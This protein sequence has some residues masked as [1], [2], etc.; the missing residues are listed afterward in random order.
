MVKRLFITDFDGT[1]LRDDKQ[2]STKDIE[3]LRKMQN[4]DVICTIATGRSLYS[5]NK[6]ADQIKINSKIEILPIDYIIF[7][8]G[9][10]VMR[11]ADS[12]I[13]YSETLEQA[14]V[15]KIVSYFEMK[16]FDYMVHGG[17]RETH[18]FG[19]K[20]NSVCN[21]DFEARINLYQD[22][23]TPL[24]SNFTEFNDSTEVIAIIPR[25]IEASFLDEI[26]SDL[27]GYS[28][29]HA[30]SPLDHQSAWIEVFNKDV[31]KSRTADWL[32]RHLNI[33][34]ENII[35]VGND[36]ND[37]DLLAWTARGFI[38]ENAPIKLKKRFE[39]VLSNNESGVSHA[40]KV[41]GFLS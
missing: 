27:P 23:A 32:S 38:V 6:A 10:G 12:K 1:L 21:P 31:S 39:I 15:K 4:N 17:I 29:I 26:Q 8:T 5:F 24:N 34:K 7:S 37:E 16:R 3:S 20:K 40:A 25:R 18:K 19:Y 30:T 41:S 22:Y 9:A 13:L 14:D 35:S 28:V 36:Y 33:K 2:I 11:Y